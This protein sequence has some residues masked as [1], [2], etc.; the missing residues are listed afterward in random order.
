MLRLLGAVQRVR[1][2]L[3]DEALLCVGLRSPPEEAAAGYSVGAYGGFGRLRDP[4]ESG[5]T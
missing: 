5:A 4:G 1:L 2:R 3:Q